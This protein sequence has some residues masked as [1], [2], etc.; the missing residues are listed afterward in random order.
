MNRRR[1]RSLE[2]ARRVF[3]YTLMVV[4]VSVLLVILTLRVLGYQFNLETR[5]V[6]QTGLVQYNSFPRGAMVQIDGNQYETT[7]TK[8]TVLPGQHQFAMSLKGYENWHKTLDIKA[9]TVT[10]L[11]YVRLVP[12]EKKIESVHEFDQLES[13]KTS[14][15]SRFMAGI[16]HDENGSLAI[17]YIDFRDSRRPKVSEQALDLNKLSGY[18]DVTT[19]HSF[20]IVE[21]S[22]GGR[23]LIL[24]HNFKTEGGTDQHEWLMADR[25]SPSGLVNITRLIN[26]PILE[27]HM[28]EGKEAYMLQEGGDIRRIVI[29]SGLVS[30]PI[31][32]GVESFGIYDADSIAYVGKQGDQRVTGV[33][34]R[35]W[36]QPTL[37][38]KLPR[39]DK[40]PVHV[41]ISKYF[42]KDTVVVASG[43]TLTI[44]RGTLP[45]SEEAK[46][47]FL[48][49]GKT[50]TLN[51]QVGNLQISSNGRFVVA[52]DKSGF[53]TYDLERDSTSQELRKYQ[54]SKINWLDEYHVWQVDETGHLI[55]QEFDGINSHQLMPAEAGQDVVLT[56]DNKYIYGFAKKEDGKTELR[57]LYMTIN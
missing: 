13:V 3:V 31:I 17:N 7:Q 35:G 15:D 11:S 57:R 43:P 16:S 6:E 51:R 39:T 2:L 40:S 47:A 25:E 42:F 50:F 52:E 23:Y 12:T 8:N 53:V 1:P 48:Q 4:A 5:T 36:T 38:S 24:K 19:T 56:S 33:W 32:S 55:M 21:W 34:R 14:A 27:I 26:L 9:G 49:T 41:A 45:G 10:W 18:E 29:D 37:I 46:A 28:A 22:K 20:E 30:G 54:P 44:Y